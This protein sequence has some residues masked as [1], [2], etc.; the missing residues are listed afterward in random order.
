MRLTGS[1]KQR[2][3][4]WVLMASCASAQNSYG[5]DWAESIAPAAYTSCG[6]SSCDSFADQ[7][8]ANRACQRGTV[9]SLFRWSADPSAGE[10]AQP[11]E[12]LVSDRPDF[13]EASSVVGLG[14]LQL[15]TGYTYTFDDNGTDR[16]VGH[17]YPETLFRYGVLANWLEFRLAWNYGNEDANGV[18]TSGADDLYLG[19]KIGLTPQEGLR[20]EMAIIP[21]MTV[22][23]GGA[24]R[25]DGEA[26]PGLNWLYGWDI[27]DFFSTAG[28]T[29]FNRSIDGGTSN[30][31]T[32]WA[33]SWTVGYSLAERLGGYTEYYGFYPSG[34]D[35]DRVKHYFN[36]GLAYSISND[37]QWDI[38]GGKGLN[39]AAD[40]YFVG[41]GLVIRFR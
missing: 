34:A 9:G 32:Q 16:A 10:L 41:S 19:F 17:S 40:D 14:I 38:R 4:A 36:G 7:C 22:P 21:Q 20:P 28:S 18:S 24:G 11:D 39:D 35:T 2:M 23:T 26:L 8:R 13:T 30:A 1:F 15:E 29:Q 27:N 12:P 33:Q 25:T 37:V 3:F 31:Y 6:E 5:Q